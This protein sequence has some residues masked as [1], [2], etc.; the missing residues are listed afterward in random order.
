MSDSSCTPTG[1]TNMAIFAI[2]M[3]GDY[4]VD[5][6]ATNAGN[7]AVAWYTNDGYEDFTKVT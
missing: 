1:K 3:D 4:D 2:D 6:L 7:D 5:F